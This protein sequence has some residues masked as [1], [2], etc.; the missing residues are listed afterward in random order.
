MVIHPSVPTGNAIRILLVEDHPIVGEEIYELLGTYPNIDLIGRAQDGEEAVLKVDALQPAVVV[1]DINLPK[2]DGIAATR[3][4]KRRHP[5]IVVIGLTAAR[6]EYLVY[7]MLK[8][9]AHDVLAKEKAGTDLYTTIQRGVAAANTILILKED[10]H[11]S[12]TTT[13]SD[14]SSELSA[15]RHT[16]NT[17]PKTY[18][19][20]Q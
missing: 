20:P 15:G 7:T 14:T 6:E 2:M 13:S 9:G 19:D 17:D 1:M 11:P 10:Q 5:H 4:I 8:A 12:D 16:A 18:D 3:L